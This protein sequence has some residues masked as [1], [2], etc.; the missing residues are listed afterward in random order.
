MNTFLCQANERGDS[1]AVITIKRFSIGLAY[2]F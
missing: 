1:I 2:V